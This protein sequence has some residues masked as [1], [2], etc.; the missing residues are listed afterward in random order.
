LFADNQAVIS[1]TEENLQ[2]AAYKLEQIITT[3]G[4]ITSAQKTKLVAVR[5]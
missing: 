1:N 4:L 5:G 3:C 2:R